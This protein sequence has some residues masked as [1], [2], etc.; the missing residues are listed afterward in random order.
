MQEIKDEDRIIGKICRGEL[1]FDRDDI[2]NL[3]NA[4]LTEAEE[5]N[6]IK[7]AQEIKETVEK[8][9]N[10]RKEMKEK[11]EFVENSDFIV[12][13]AISKID[14]KI[15]E[16]QNEYDQKRYTPSWKFVGASL[17][18]LIST[19]G[20]GYIVS[21]ITPAIWALI[22]ASM[23]GFFGSFGI[24]A[25]LAIKSQ[26]R[27]D[28]IKERIKDLEKSR[29]EIIADGVDESKT[30]ENERKMNVVKNIYKTRKEEKQHI[31]ILDL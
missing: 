24:F 21:L 26:N 7:L 25:G 11:L 22:F 31:D 5:E 14:N 23:G 1:F 27:L 12:R 20:L 9:Q 6:L 19:F 17:I 13:S 18:M 16:L 4:N 8:N 3:A 2:K 10:L 28:A 29:L 30:Q 15:Q